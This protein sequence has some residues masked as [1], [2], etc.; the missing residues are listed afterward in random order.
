MR[1]QETSPDEVPCYAKAGAQG[2]VSVVDERISE[3][4]PGRGER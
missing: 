2:V 3:G 4:R 1:R